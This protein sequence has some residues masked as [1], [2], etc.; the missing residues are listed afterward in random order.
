MVICFTMYKRHLAGSLSW[1]TQVWTVA[2]DLYLILSFSTI[3]TTCF[4][5][6]YFIMLSIS[7]LIWCTYLTSCYLMNFLLQYCL[8]I[9]RAS[10]EYL[11]D[12]GVP[13]RLTESI[14]LKSFEFGAWKRTEKILPKAGLP[15]KLIKLKFRVLHLHR[16]LGYSGNCRMF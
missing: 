8:S 2:P 7:F 13:C 15:M 11:V 9:H 4:V 6:D 12:W 5:F 3:L 14:L 1:L 16:I 10:Q